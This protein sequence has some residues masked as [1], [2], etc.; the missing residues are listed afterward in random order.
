MFSIIIP[1][2]WRANDVFYQALQSYIKWDLIDDIII[3]NN[4]INNT[5]EWEELKHF[6]IKV[7]NQESNIYVN[8]AWNLGVEVSIN[9]KIGILNDDIVFDSTLF[10][11]LQDEVVPENGVF[12]IIT[13]E[14][15]FN[16]PQYTD[17]SISFKKWNNGDNIHGFGQ[18]MF[19]H[20]S[21]WLPIID[22][23]KIYYGD[24]YIFKTHLSKGLN[25]FLIYNI[26]FFSPMASTSKDKSITEGY[27]EKEKPFFTEWFLYGKIKKDDMKTILIAI[28]TNKY[29]EPETFKSI[30]DLEVPDGYKTEFQFFY[31]Y[32]IDQIRNLIAEWAKRYDYLF[33]VDSDVSFK[34]DTLKK[35]IE[36]DKPVVS[37]LYIQR[38]PGYHILELYRN[39]IN[40]PY[41]DIRN[42]GLIE[43][44]GCGF[45]CVLVKSEIFRKMEYPHFFYKSALDHKNTVSEDNYFCAKAKS[46][47]Y[48]IY[49]DTNI[50]C[51]HIGST[52]FIVDNNY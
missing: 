15:K 25:N 39:G 23:L 28:P 48:K 20:K 31:G 38:K 9:D 8:P 42:A 14:A 1:T 40:I 50:Q 5:P 4:D 26:R 12:G 44:D 35:L 27:L 19:L 37:G 34:P 41:D 32:Q 29:I 24:D 33:S 46:I 22:E 13:G 51:Q 36:H 21:N 17:G 43:I 2:M 6:K 10:S 30:Y 3:I 18:A 7:L 11:K 52:K 45:G 49:A 47:G 16:H